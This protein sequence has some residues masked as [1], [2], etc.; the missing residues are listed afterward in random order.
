MFATA[1]LG[2]TLASL[3]CTL[4]TSIAALIS[5][6]VFQGFCGGMLIPAVFTSVFV[7]MP[8][9]HRVLATTIAGVFAVIAPTV[10]PGG[11]RLPDGDIFL[12]LDF[13]GQYSSGSFR[14][15]YGRAFWCVSAR[16]IFRQSKGSIIRLLFSRRSFWL[17]WNYSLAKAPGTIGAAICAFLGRGLHRFRRTRYWRALDHASPFIDLRRFRK[18]SFSIGLRPQFRVWLRPLWLGLYN[19][20]VSRAC[21]GTFAA[22]DR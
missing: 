18:R 21:T 7:M 3:G 2:F 12:A 10:G 8:E 19:V 16:R 11:W 15:G 5:I 22:G 14:H 4:S 20:A 9:K 17:R 13:F 6:R 1:T